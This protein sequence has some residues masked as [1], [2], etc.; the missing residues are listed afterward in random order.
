MDFLNARVGPEAA[1]SAMSY[2]TMATSFGELL[3]P[4]LGGVVYDNAGQM[5]VFGIA[6]AVISIDG[7]LRLLVV[8]EQASKDEM[9]NDAEAGKTTQALM[10]DVDNIDVGSY[11][12]LST[13][14]DLTDIH[15]ARTIEDYKSNWSIFVRDKDFMISL[16]AALLTSTTRSALETVSIKPPHMSLLS[17]PNL[18]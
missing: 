7:I 4:M 15:H 12:S 10:S 16:G 3:G 13:S 9:Y 18:Q 14:P 5:A 1:G 17:V 8:D 2:F 6:A 11:D